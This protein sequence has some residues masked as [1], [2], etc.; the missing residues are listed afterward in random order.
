MVLYYV[1]GLQMTTFFYYLLSA[2]ILSKQF[3][4]PK[5]NIIDSLP[6]K[7]DKLQA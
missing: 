5:Q 2:R 3:D 7:D 1:N 6:L 4:T